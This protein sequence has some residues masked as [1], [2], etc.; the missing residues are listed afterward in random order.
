MRVRVEASSL[1]GLREEAQ[2][3]TDVPLELDR[4]FTV[5]D[6]VC[7]LQAMNKVYL[8][9]IK[10]GVAVLPIRCNR[11]NRW[12]IGDDPTVTLLP[13]GME[14]TDIIVVD[15]LYHTVHD[16]ATWLA[17]FEKGMHS[18]EIPDERNRHAD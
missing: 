18:I 1:P 4:R 13:E 9:I 16:S 8:H 2:L 11:I 10:I 14:P 3:L 17:A 7:C 15:L 6:F 5:A 12:I